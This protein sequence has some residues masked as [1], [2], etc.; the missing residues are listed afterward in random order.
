MRFI[1]ITTEEIVNRPSV[2]SHDC[3]VRQIYI[4][5]LKLLNPSRI[6][7]ITFTARDFSCNDF[8]PRC[9]MI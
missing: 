4:F 3:D 2:S 6:Y 8:Y 9:N 1:I 7:K 5:C